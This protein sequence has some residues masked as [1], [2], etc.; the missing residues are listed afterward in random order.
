[1]VE[2]NDF[3]KVH[4]LIPG[5]YPNVGAVSVSNLA[6]IRMRV[7]L[8]A[9]NASLLGLSL[10]VGDHIFSR[11]QT[12]II[13]KI[14]AD[15]A[16]GRADFWLRQLSLAKQASK[17]IVLDYTDHHL[18]RMTSPMGSFYTQALPLVDE[19][20]VS[21]DLMKTH[22]EEFFNAHIHVIAD[23]LEIPITPPCTSAS[24]K[25]VRTVLWFGHA[26]NI[27][28][29]MNYLSDQTRC[30]AD[31]KLI[32]LSNDVGLQTFVSTPLTAKGQ[33]HVHVQPWS[34]KEMR[35]AAQY[36]DACIIPSDTSDPRKSGASS[37]RLLT[38]FAL[39]LP[40]LAENLAS[41]A[42]FNAFY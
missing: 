6:S 18:G 23:P 31:F 34:I 36:S 39:G 10:T 42:P 12:V 28:Y 17:R 30:D 16:Q 35:V 22:L 29:L 33:I 3:K 27:S 9:Q 26:T 24:D 7:G 13:G 11:S 2:L 25:P 40:T 37:N 20:V 38:A 4:W 14:G 8:V 5:D 41:Y 1:M 21:S 32:V 15:C 19:A